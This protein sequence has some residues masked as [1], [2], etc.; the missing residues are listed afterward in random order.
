MTLDAFVKEHHTHH[1]VQF[2]T[3]LAQNPR[4]AQCEI[5]KEVFAVSDKMLF[6]YVKPPRW[7]NLDPD[8]TRMVKIS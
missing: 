7:V 8:K 6:W 1:G 4:H 3:L 2:L 5:C